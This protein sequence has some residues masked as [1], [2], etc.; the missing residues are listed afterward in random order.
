MA[1]AMAAPSVPSL[2]RVAICA[3]LLV[4]L[5]AFAF[6][7]G[8][9]AAVVGAWLVLVSLPRTFLSRQ[10]TTVRAPRLRN[11]AIYFSAVILVFVLNGINNGIAQ[12]RATG[13]V[14]AVHAYHAANK[15]YPASL[16]QLVPAH[17]ASVPRAKYT[18]LFSD[19]TYF[20]S[21]DDARLLYVD[22][23][24]YGRPVYSFNQKSWGYLD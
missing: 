21:G 16:A 22:L 8:A 3:A 24:P 18:L 1:S 6:N 4:F 12:D 10:F 17:I 23:P 7:Q 14:T 13:L 20:A 15:A 2:P 9:I 11:I 19:F 5:D